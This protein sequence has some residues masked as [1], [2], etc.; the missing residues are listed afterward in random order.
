MSVVRS[1]PELA[2]L[3]ALEAADQMDSP[4]AVS[5]LRVALTRLPDVQVP[6]AQGADLSAPRAISFEPGGRRMA[7]ADGRTAPRIVDMESGTTSDLRAGG[8]A[9]VANLRWSPDGALIAAVDT[10]GNTIISDAA[11]GNRVAETHG[12]LYWRRSP[13]KGGVRQ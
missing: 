1:D 13:G 12:E 7:I 9:P 8:A 5:A 3:L 10:D 4:A 6:V 11:K 2:T